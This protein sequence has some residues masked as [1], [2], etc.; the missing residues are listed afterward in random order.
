MQRPQVDYNQFDTDSIKAQLSSRG[1]SIKGSREKLINRLKSEVDKAWAQYNKS[2]RAPLFPNTQPKKIKPKKPKKSP[3]EIAKEQAALAIKRQEKLK[4]KQEHDKRVEEARERK[5][6]KKEE[7]AKKQTEQVAR[8]KQEKE[9]RQMC[10]AFLGF[11]VRSFEQQVRKRLD[12][13][14]KKIAS[15]SYDTVAKRFK[16]KFNTAADAGRLTKGITMKK[17]KKLKFDSSVSVLPS[18]VESRCVMFLYPMSLL[19]PDLAKAK[20]WCASKGMADSKDSELLQAWIQ[21]ALETFSSYGTIVNV[22]RERGF[23]VVN[24]TNQGEASRMVGSAKTFNGCSFIHLQTG[25]PTKLDK[26][27]VDKDHG[28][29]KKTGAVKPKN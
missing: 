5:R 21:S 13:S 19:H 7:K 10:E 15:C 12:P 6:A 14:G 11:D 22:F 24:F 9:K 25:T 23:L 20:A 18:P 3:E 2:N 16:V 29:V 1:L 27:I 26:R 28:P 4:R 8:Q 17:P